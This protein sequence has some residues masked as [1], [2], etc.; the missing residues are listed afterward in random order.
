MQSPRFSDL[1]MRLPALGLSACLLGFLLTPFLYIAIGAL[2]AF[3]SVFSVLAIPPFLLSVCFLLN[4]L[5]SKPGESGNGSVRLLPELLSWLIIMAFIFVISGFTL[6]NIFERVG[7][8]C[9]MLIVSNVMALAI[10]I[11]RHATLT[12]RMQKI[13]LPI[14]WGALVLSLVIECS[15]AVIYGVA[16]IDFI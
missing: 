13:P 4:L 5:L 3:S 11:P 10:L 16:A 6:L 12:M 7:L 2:S 9:L 8:F 1:F 14:A 15:G